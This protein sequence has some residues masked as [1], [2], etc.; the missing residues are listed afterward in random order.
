[1]AESIISN[2]KICYLCKT[3]YNIHKHHIYA[4]TGRRDNAEKYG[5]WVYLCAAHHNMSDYA[6]HFNKTLDLG[7]K[8]LCQERWEEIYGTREEFRTVFGKSY[9]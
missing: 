2:E 6:V 8:K 7:L 1:M 4:G 5:C 3:P 9:L